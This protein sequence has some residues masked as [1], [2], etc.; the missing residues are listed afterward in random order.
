[1]SKSFGRK[2]RIIITTAAML[3]IGGG[4][5]FAYWSAAGT[6]N[7]TATADAAAANYTVTSVV[8]GAALSPGSAA[9]TV[10]F[11]VKNESS[12]GQR[13][14]NVAVTVADVNG[15]AWAGTGCSAADF[16]VGPVLVASNP[17][18]ATE[19]DAGATLTGTVTLQM[20]NRVGVDQ[21]GCKGAT[22]PLHVAAS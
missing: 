12:G 2:K 21:N 4:A 7:T 11:T 3:A 15:L 17:F 13:L 5:A 10:T 9:Q 20:N 18:A 19:I 6:S 16:T 8:T 14:A 22:V 1:M